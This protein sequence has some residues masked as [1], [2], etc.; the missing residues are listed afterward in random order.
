VAPGRHTIRVAV[1]VE[2]SRVDTGSGF[3][4]VSQP[5]NITIRPLATGQASSWPPGPELARAFKQMIYWAGLALQESPRPAQPETSGWIAAALA[6]ARETTRLAEHTRLATS[7]AEMVKT[8]TALQQAVQA[9]PA[10]AADEFTA[11]SKVHGHM[12]D[13]F[14]GTGDTVTNSVAESPQSASK[15]IAIQVEA[16]FVLVDDA[17]VEAM[18][19]ELP[20]KEV[21][22]PEDVNA[23]HAIGA[24]LLAG[25]TP[26]LELAQVELLLRAVQRSRISKTLAV[27]R[28]T[29]LDG[30]AA[31]VNHS[32]QLE[33][34]SGY[35][36][37]NDAGQE[38]VPQ[39]RSKSLG[40]AFD[41][42]PH[43]TDNSQ[44]IRVQFKAE[45]NSLLDMHEALYQGKYAYDVPSFETVT[46]QSEIVIPDGQVAL[47]HGPRVRSLLGTGPD[48]S[49]PARP[50]FV[51]VRPRKTTLAPTR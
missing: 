14:A 51:L 31:T 15:K 36:A 1:F 46:L 5:M 18:Q 4:L 37:S 35:R 8:L 10:Q 20:I 39:R 47:I 48:K 27:P 30:D 24:D 12:I 22:A 6:R 50:L 33:Y 42:T 7:A 17:F 23:L 41:V 49:K 29:V 45:I 40:L 34:V 16:R 25:R 9:D 11:V 43:L 44:N 13:V 38:P 32:E 2:P 21:T 28:V 19:R 26:L 3:R